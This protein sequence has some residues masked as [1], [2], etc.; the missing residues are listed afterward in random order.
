[1]HFRQVHRNRV[2]T[3]RRLQFAIVCVLGGAFV[4]PALLGLGRAPSVSGCVVSAEAETA[5][6]TSDGGYVESVLGETAAGGGTI[7]VGGTPLSQV[8]GSGR[9]VSLSGAGRPIV[10]VR[11][12][13][14]GAELF[15]SPISADTTM[16]AKVAVGRNGDVDVF[17]FASERQASRAEPT[18]SADLYFARAS[19]RG[20]AKPERV[21]R[22]QNVIVGPGRGSSVVRV[23][24]ERALAFAL[25]PFEASSGPRLG[26]FGLVLIHGRPQAWRVDTLR[27]AV[28]VY[29][30]DLVREQRA[31]AWAVVFTAP[32]VLGDGR[33]NAAV[34]YWSSWS[35]GKWTPPQRTDRLTTSQERKE[36]GLAWLRDGV[37][38]M[39]SVR[40]LAGATERVLLLGAAD[41]ANP[42]PEQ[43]VS[44]VASQQAVT[45]MGDSL[46]IMISAARE[47]VDSLDWTVVSG[48][49]LHGRGRIAARHLGL[50]LAVHS[51]GNGEALLLTTDKWS[52]GT[53][54]RLTARERRLH[55]RCSS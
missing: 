7:A 41:V 28:P 35:D 45:T 15:P 32:L 17:F 37:V 2:D 9:G 3:M 29:S 23:G 30:V 4:L 27:F 10:A 34:T 25:E 11:P 33:L 40:R 20:L 51:M 1:M 49:R 5:M 18:L 55:I 38:A 52:D 46:L 43:V 31:G 16:G 44:S 19:A 8:A 26:T 14:Q 50:N 13:T 47:S 12:A 54:A 22:L 53:D 48:I 21:A 6:R 24:E 36:P 42:R 39:W